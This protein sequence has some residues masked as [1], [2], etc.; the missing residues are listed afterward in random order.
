MGDAG[1]A[2]SWILIVLWPRLSPE[3]NDAMRTEVAKLSRLWMHCPAFLAALGDANVMYHP[4]PLSGRVT[5]F[6]ELSLSTWQVYT[7]QTGS[8]D[9]PLF[10]SCQTHPLAILL[11]LS[12]KGSVSLRSYKN[13]KYRSREES[14]EKESGR[15]KTQ[16][17]AS[18]EACPGDRRAPHCPIR[19]TV[20]IRPFVARMTG[21][22]R[23]WTHYAAAVQLLW[24]RRKT[25]YHTIL[26]P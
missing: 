19:H 24:H 22:N 13:Q 20:F 1:R 14:R 7:A 26:C 10:Q 3:T 9:C 4:W 5:Y 16:K 8:L 2:K 15:S 21:D 25:H 6:Q 17:H 11:C 12:T 18:M 23:H